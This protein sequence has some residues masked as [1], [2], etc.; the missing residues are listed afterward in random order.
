MV[1]DSE[2][3]VK[4]HKLLIFGMLFALFLAA[5]G[6]G[7]D[8][9]APVKMT[10]YE[11]DTL[12]VEYPEAWK[13]SSM[14]MFGMTIAI[15]SPIEM[16]QEALT[17]M[18]DPFA[19]LGDDPLTMIIALPEELAGQF[20]L[21]DLEDQIPEDEDVSIV[22]QGDVTISGASGKEVVAKGRVA[23]LGDKMMGIH[24]AVLEKDGAVV[25]FVG[26]TPEKDLDKN[27]EIF[28]YMIKNMEL[29]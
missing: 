25:M 1:F 3:I 29:K 26:M 24:V 27:L 8:G 5:C 20:G 11:G 12:S 22:R 21:E 15:F 6:G 17:A 7:G 9:G 18:D 4:T 14:E 10:E 23:E 16:G 19:L 28:D 2:V 13:D